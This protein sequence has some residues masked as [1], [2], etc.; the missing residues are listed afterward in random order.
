MGSVLDNDCLQANG[1]YDGDVA[2]VGFSLKLPG[3]AT[4]PEKFWDMLQAGRTAASEFPPDRINLEG[5]YHPDKSRLDQMP[6]RGGYFLSE[7]IDRF[8]APFFSISPAEAACME[9]QQRHMLETCYRAL[10]NVHTGSFTDDYRSVLFH[11]RLEGHMYAATGLANSILANRIS[12]FFNLIGPSLN[13]DTACSSSLTAL[14]LACQDLRNGTTDM[15]LVGGCNL[16]YH[17]DYMLMMS[18]MSFLSTDSRSWSLDEKANGYARGEGFGVLV[19][20]RLCDAVR[21]GDTVRAVIRATRLNQDGRTPG[22]TN[23]SGAAHKALIL[24]AYSHAQIDMEPT[25]FFEAHSTGTQ[26]GD[27]TEANAVGEAFSNVRSASDPLWIGAVKTNVGHLEA[28][29]GMASLFKAI[30]VLEKGIIPPNACFEK[31]NPRIQADR[32][33]IKVN[34]FGFGGSNGVVILDDAYHYPRSRGFVVPNRTRPDPPSQQ[35][36]EVIQSRHEMILP[37]SEG[38]MIS[39]Y[40]PGVFVWS[41]SDEDG[42]KRIQSDLSDFFARH[43]DEDLTT[44]DFKDIA[45]TLGVKRTQL[46][47]RRSVAFSSLADL[48]EKLTSSLP[49][50]K[51]TQDRHAALVFTGQGAQYAGMGRGLITTSRVFR[52][53]MRR[54]QKLLGC[55]GCEWKLEDVM[56]DLESPE[57]ACID[58]PQYSQPVCTALQI[59]LVDLLW[60]LGIWPRAVVGH[61]SGEIA[62]AYSTGALSRESALQVAFHRGRL[63]AKL[64]TITDCKLSMMAVGLGAAEAETHLAKLGEHFSGT[65]GRRVDIACINSPKNVTL[66]GDAEQIVFLEGL[67]HERGIF[68]RKLKIDM[69]YHSRF[70]TPIAQE[71]QDCLRSLHSDTQHNRPSIMFSSVTGDI[72]YPSDLVSPEYWVKNMTSAVRFSDAVT[73]LSAQAGRKRKVLGQKANNRNNALRISDM[74]EVGPHHALRGPARE[75]LQAAGKTETIQYLSTLTRPSPSSHTVSHPSAP[76][77]MMALAGR[78]WTLGY[79]IDLLAANDLP[80]NLP[81]ALRV[82]LPEY[83]FNHTQ[84][85]WRESRVARN[86]RLRDTPHHDFLGVRSDDWN[87]KQAHWRDIVSEARLPWLRDHKLAGEY[88]YPA[89]G[90]IT[91]A[92]EAARQLVDPKTHASA[93]SSFE[94]RQVQFLNAFRSLQGSDSGME[95]RFTLIP[96]AQNPQWSAFNLFIYE[97]TGWV[98]VCRGQIRTYHDSD[99][100]ASEMTEG[101]RHVNHHLQRWNSREFLRRCA[102]TNNSFNSKTFYDILSTENDAAYGPAFQTL[103]NISASATGEVVADIHARKWAEHYSDQYV[104][105]HIIHP[106]TVDALFQ[107]VFPALLGTGN[108]V[109]PTH[110]GRMWINARGLSNLSQ[111]GLSRLQA[112]G[113]CTTRGHRGT[114]VRARVVDPE[115]GLPLIDLE[116]YEAT[117]VA[118]NEGADIEPRKL[119]AT[120]QWRPDIDALDSTA[121]ERVITEE[122][123]PNAGAA[124]SQFHAELDLVI[125]HFLSEALEL[126]KDANVNQ[127]CSKHGSNLIR[128]VKYQTDRGLFK[129]GA[130]RARQERVAQD[131]SFRESIIERISSSVPEG[132]VLTLLAHN[133]HAIILG[134]VD[135]K[136]LLEEDSLAHQYEQRIISESPCTPPLTRYLDLLGHKNPQMRILEIG[137]GSGA[138]TEV[139]TKA[140]LQGGRPRWSQ[141]HCTDVSG[142]GFEDAHQR[143]DNLLNHMEF[144]VLEA[145]GDPT[146]QGFEDS[147]YDLVLAGNVIHKF[148]DAKKIIENAHNLLKP[149]GRLIL[150][151]DTNP[152][153]IRAGLYCGA[154]KDWWNDIQDQGKCTP[155]LSVDSWCHVLQGS[156][157][158][159]PEL[160]LK[161]SANPELCETSILVTSKSL[162]TN[163]ALTGNHVQGNSV[164]GN[165]LMNGA[166]IE[167][168]TIL[169]D[170]RIPKQRSLALVLQDQLNSASGKNCD[171]VDVQSIEPGCLDSASCISLLEVDRPFLARLEREEFTTL[172]QIVS[173]S[174]DILWVSQ[175]SAKPSAPEFSLIDG[176]A[177]VMRGEYPTLKLVTL[178]LEPQ[179]KLLDTSL[180]ILDRWERMMRT[181]HSH[182]EAECRLRNG[183]IEIPRVVHSESMNHL[184]ATRSKKRQVVEKYRLGDAP[185]LSVRVDSPGVLD[186][187]C[188]HEIDNET[189]SK[190]LAED[191]VLV[192]AR[193]FGLG[194]RD[195]L[196]ASGRLNEQNM[197]M[198]LAG[199][200][201]EAGATSGLQT[202]DRVCVVRPDGFQTLVRCKANTVTRIP[203]NMSNADASLLSVASIVAL[204]ALTG[205]GQL[206]DCDTVLVHNAASTTG[207]VLIQLAQSIKARVLAIAKTREQRRMLADVYKI[208]ASH[209]LSKGGRRVLDVTEGQGVDLVVALS[210]SQDETEFLLECLS[211]MG[212]FVLVSDD[213]Q[214]STVGGQIGAN[215]SF[216]RLDVT[217]LFRG[218]PNY[219]AK[220]LRKAETLL[221][222]GTVYPVAGV[223]TLP[224][225]D[226]KSALGFFAGG[227]EIGGSVIELREDSFVKTNLVVRPLYS[228]NANSTYVISGG[229]GGIGRSI[230]RWM[231]ARG[232]RY[233]LLLSRSGT[234]RPAAQALV[235][236][237]T[238]QGAQVLAPPCDITN[239]DELKNVVEDASQVMPPIKG[240]IQGAMVLR[241]SI[242]ENMSWDDWSESSR[243]KVLGSWNL[244]LAMPSGLDFFTLLS[245]ISCILG[246]V[247]QSNYA[248]GNAYMNALCHYR[249][250]IGERASSAVNLGMLVTEGV[251]A[252]SEELLA[253]MRGMGQFM[254][255]QGEEMFALLEQHLQPRKASEDDAESCQPIFGI[256]LPAAMEA[257]GKEVPNYLTSPMFRHFHYADT[258]L[259]NGRNMAS[260]ERQVDFASAISRAETTAQVAGDMIQWLTTKMSRVLGLE[261]ADINASKPISSYGIDSLIGMEIRNWFERDLGAKIAIFELLSTT[262]SIAD[263]CASAATRS[264]FRSEQTVG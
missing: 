254:E 229:L 170:D 107:L 157:F 64:R 189:T 41:S 15:G 256:Q 4:S 174:K 210:P 126:L 79:P 2:I 106:A 197:G 1:A 243:P 187:V 120:M 117:I 129:D 80:H 190:L 69:A 264:R 43:S 90:M 5:H 140:L 29:S 220:L 209:I 231:V 148:K 224:A 73:R 119:C 160:V 166:T 30:L 17:P 139:V 68:A 118:G 135:A 242:F 63:A 122:Q 138:M 161:D 67:L 238:S 47:W 50:G 180:A 74:I 14:H 19:I 151:E 55:M 76:G 142:D 201:V 162:P 103:D 46:S 147:T 81:R 222:N 44:D 165:S 105:S 204:H 18:N 32:Y 167:I 59:A 248:A 38:V 141:Y 86:Y 8:D 218:R 154:T 127:D 93:P 164:N 116:R 193:A 183:L 137:A 244:H 251:V 226:T 259:K 227:D 111:R 144:R 84:V 233:L 211:S 178:A 252:E 207:Q 262:N 83:P 56:F 169:V 228:F 57:A 89:G 132:R 214:A 58:E 36:I 12:W 25:R 158:G 87:E 102:N 179:S 99:E 237:L 48:K 82:D 125:R 186:S 97:A 16:I 40:Q 75:I 176:F 257:A 61:S 181:D 92:V 212:R 203:E 185:P 110:V 23:P 91:M 217:E 54:N 245:S 198:Q 246:G 60:S 71:Y 52:E 33:H 219:A 202:G 199:V 196:I 247:S 155:L 100:Y 131:V 236:E 177:R 192:R 21:D 98:E 7:K 20:K 146:K 223:L 200:V 159:G 153:A 168:V 184:I 239:I 28:G 232:A 66:S 213:Q 26:A 88:L 255:I 37:E 152:D 35:A 101:E 216:S 149:G 51:S 191:E 109:V 49:K 11:D 188:Y 108:T 225:E 208:P 215:A 171:C 241:D 95:T 113:L 13:L 121:L 145:T 194:P 253:V 263:L 24:E 205:S 70:M 128:W 42:L 31:L 123:A 65:G 22:L 115:T 77:D 234:S 62:A 45:Y 10:E 34:S 250:S 261:I 249:H 39:K 96:E 136:Q 130:A 27:P 156:G 133:M 85:H 3:E 173:S 195:Y 53:S 150:L 112:Q 78:L 134:R 72:V 240:C 221:Q 175:D 206:E 143:F 235:D 258:D 104:S 9:P 182:T 230:A 172:R 260:A 163:D 114:D 124:R 94:L 6:L